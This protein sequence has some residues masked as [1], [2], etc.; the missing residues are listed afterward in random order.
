MEINILTLHTGSVTDLSGNP[1]ALWGTN[2]NVYITPPTIKSITPGKNAIDVQGNQS[3]AIT[4]TEPIKAGSLW[5]VL[6]NSSGVSIPITTS[7]NGN[8]LTITP[9]DTMMLT[10]GEYILTLHTGC[11][12][13]LAGIPLK[14]WGTNFGVI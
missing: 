7:I 5:I 12:T 1:Q 8:I 14:L 10:K 2:F 3:I 9:K 6:Q 4:F 13:G 11:V